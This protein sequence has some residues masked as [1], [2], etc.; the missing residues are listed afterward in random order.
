MDQSIFSP[1][2]VDLRP[3]GALLPPALRGLVPDEP[4]Q[5]VVRT[6]GQPNLHEEKV[7]ALELAYTGNIAERTT[8][9]LAV[10]QNVIDDNNN[11]VSVT[12]DAEHP[13]GLPGSRSPSTRA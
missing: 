3:L 7:D 2:A 4:F 12:P 6:T 1:S 13:Q 9:G 8:L 10:Y 5:L 11:F